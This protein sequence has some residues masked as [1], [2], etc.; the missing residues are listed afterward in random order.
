MD[1]NLFSLKYLILTIITFSVFVS[2]N[3]PSN[4]EKTNSSCRME[5]TVVDLKGLDGC[6]IMFQLKSGKKLLPNN[7]EDYEGEFSAGKKVMIS[8]EELKDYASIC[9]AEDAIVQIE[10]LEF[11]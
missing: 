2:C 4:G 9:M 11:L 7:L 1:K 3:T 5:A 8:F 6:G 10:C